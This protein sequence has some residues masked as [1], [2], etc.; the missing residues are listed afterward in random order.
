MTDGAP[1]GEFVEWRHPAGVIRAHYHERGQGDYYVVLVQTGG[2][3]SN[4][5]MSWF[6]NMDAFAADGYHV[7]APDMIGFG[8]SEIV[9]QP[10]KRIDTSSFLAGFVDALGITDAHWMGNSMGSNA[11][12]RLAIDHPERVRSLIFTGGEP[13]VDD[14]RSRAISRELGKTAR[15]DFLREMFSKPEVSFEDMRRATA[16]FFYDA[17]HPAVDLTTAMRLEAVRRP[18]VHQRERDAAFGQAARGRETFQA[19]D[20]ARIRAP[21]YLVHGRDEEN[22]YPPEY[23]QILTESAMRACLVIPECSCTLIA[24]CGH[25]PQIEKSETFNALALQF[26]NGVKGHR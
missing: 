22:F 7:V 14:D 9:D 25:W 16:P 18:G 17:T 26:L 20:L 24:R 3:G 5:Y 23:A 12:V 21:S 15:V 6:L 4:A 1:L 10:G 8:L 2:A 11:I 13:R 19:D